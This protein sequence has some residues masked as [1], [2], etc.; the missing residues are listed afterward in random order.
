M[1]DWLVYPFCAP[2]IVPHAEWADI[3]DSLKQKITMERLIQTSMLSKGEVME[4]CTNAEASLYLMNMSFEVPL[5]GDW[6]NI[7]LYV[8]TQTFENVKSIPEDIKVTEL[9]EWQMRKLRDLKCWIFKQVLE[10]FK[11]KLKGMDVAK[12]VAD[13]EKIDEMRPSVTLEAYKDEGK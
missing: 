13:G 2:I 7:Y 6:T 11:E 12:K 3:P 5:G 1:I 4:E 10:G 9:D 8:A